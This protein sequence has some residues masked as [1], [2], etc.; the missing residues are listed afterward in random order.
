VA[1][2]NKS[3]CLLHSVIA[4]TVF[5]ALAVSITWATPVQAAS[6]DILKVGVLEE[7][8]SLNLWLA[9]DAWSKRVLGLMYQPLYMRE[10][11]TSKLVPWLADG[12]PDFDPKTLTCTVK[13][14]KAKWSDGTDFTAEDVAFTGEMIYLFKMPRHYSKW[15]FIQEIQVVDK[16]TVRFVLKE[17]KA[18]F[19]SRTLTTPI[20]QKK[21][22]APLVKSLEGTTQSLQQFLQHEFKEPA[23]TG[24]FNVAKWKKGV[25][26]YMKRNPHFF[27]QGQTIAGNKL[28]PHIKGIILKIY[29]TA[30]AAVL[31]L[32][33]GDIDF[34]WNNIQAG[35]LKEIED[36]PKIK[37]FQNKKSGLYYLGFNLR[38]E[39]MNDVAFRRAVA[40]LIAKDFII[41]RI[42]QGYGEVLHS[43]IPPGN[44]TFYNPDVPKY[45]FGLDTNK[46]I[47]M[48]YEILKK[49]GYTWE[50]PPVDGQGNVQKAKG[51]KTPD[52]SLMREIT[53][54]TPPADYDPH[55]AMSGQMIQE[56]LRAVGIPVVSR[57]MAFG[58]L[59]QTVKTQRDFDCFILGY[60]KLSL[61]PGYLRAFFH[62][63]MNKPKGWNMSGYENPEFDKL[64]MASDGELDLQKRRKMILK[65]QEMLIS[66]VPYVPLYNP[67]VVEGVRV[68][69]FK[70]WV[71]GLGGVGSIWS[72]CE[73]Q[74]K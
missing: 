62:S 38:R 64:A 18:I 63:R 15:K 20:V 49:A 24:P 29:G 73:I 40:S 16:H 32:R 71:Q 5:I 41:K 22:W 74:P 12:E 27:G 21:Q 10:P 17:P 13:L 70:G 46:R 14:R 28:G 2:T 59:I 39:P 61:D 68:D 35:Y 58:A 53:I 51:L 43:L 54:L 72:L 25:F 52:G 45:G 9:T 19:L 44:S 36:D 23:I 60:G 26:V 69:R 66:D 3:R 34:Y 48:A 33:K 37:I 1:H 42:L 55:R 65:M 57:P 7:P 30:D 31:A 56:W 11:T 6:K 50:V 8:K 47:K 67:T 4:F